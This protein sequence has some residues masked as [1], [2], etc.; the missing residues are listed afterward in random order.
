MPEGP[1]L[2]IGSDLFEYKGKTYLLEVDYYSRWIEIYELK[3][4][5]SKSVISKMRSLFSRLV[6]PLK[7]KIDNG[8]CYSSLEFQRFREEQDIKHTTSSPKYPQSNGLAERCV[9]MVK[10]LCDKLSDLHRSLLI[11]RA[12]PPESGLSPAELLYGRNIC[13][14]LPSIGKEKNV[15]IRKRDSDLHVRQSRNYNKTKEMD[16]VL[17]T[18]RIWIKTDLY[19]GEEEV[20]KEAEESDGYIVKKRS[21]RDYKK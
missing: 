1:W 19:D 5:T 17:P 10:R 8:V 7:I 11:Y 9:K 3:E 2:E 15:D 21:H 14:G 18:S 12:T 13:T 4:M 20:V 6:I 16:P